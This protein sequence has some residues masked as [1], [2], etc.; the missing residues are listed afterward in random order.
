MKCSGIVGE[1]SCSDLVV[2]PK[3]ITK[4]A[5]HSRSDGITLTVYPLCAS[6]RAAIACPFFPRLA[7]S[8]TFPCSTT[9]LP[10][11]E[12]EYVIDANATTFQ[13]PPG[14]PGD[15]WPSGGPDPANGIVGINPNQESLVYR[16]TCTLPKSETWICTVSLND[17]F[18]RYGV[19]PTPSQ[20]T[21]PKRTPT[22]SQ[23]SPLYVHDFNGNKLA[24]SASLYADPG[25]PASQ[26]DEPTAGT[27][28]VAIQFKFTG[29]GPGTINSDVNADTTLIGSDGQAYTP[30]TDDVKGC[31]NFSFGDFTLAP[32]QSEIGCAVFAV[33]TDVSINRVTLSLTDG[34]VDTVYWTG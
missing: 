29:D 30:S 31:T 33:P 2:W 19:N 18:D 16:A 17:V 8:L 11:E 34:A 1:D 7:A 15:G 22:P 24:A 14:V 25:T 21:K 12:H 3:G 27:R 23:H 13:D 32:G 28:L 26:F 10:P 9:S 4:P 6:G 5:S 20:S